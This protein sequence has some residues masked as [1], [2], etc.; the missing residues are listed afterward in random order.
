MSKPNPSTLTLKASEMQENW[1]AVLDGVARHEARVVVERDGIP[2]AAIISPDDLMR[3]ERLDAERH[4]RF[5]ALRA[6]QAAF[7]DI[8]DDEIARELN[9]ALAAVRDENQVRLD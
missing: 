3:L 5:G 8:P 7:A 4:E 6:S 9:A 2:V 1:S